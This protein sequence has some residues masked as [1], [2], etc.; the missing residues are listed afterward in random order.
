MAAQPAGSMGGTYGGNVVACAAANATIDA[1]YVMSN[2]LMMLNVCA[3][4]DIR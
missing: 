3:V 1:M 2:L 4:I